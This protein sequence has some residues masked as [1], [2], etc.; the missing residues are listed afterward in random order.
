M[1]DNLYKVGKLSL[2]QNRIEQIFLQIISRCFHPR[3]SSQNFG[4][5]VLALSVSSQM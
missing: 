1:H 2:P 4:L 5:D 3:R